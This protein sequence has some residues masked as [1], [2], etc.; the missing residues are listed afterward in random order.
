[1]ALTVSA[2]IAS[3]GA[4]YMQGSQGMNNLKAKLYRGA[5]FDSLF[6]SFTQEDTIVRNVKVS[7]GE[8]LQPFQKAHTPKGGVT[9]LPQ[10]INL[11]KL[12]ADDEIYPD[13]IEGTYVTF[14]AGDGVKREDW[15]IIRYWVEEVMIKQ[16]V[17]DIDTHAFTAVYAAPTAGT[18]AAAS[19]SIDGFR[20]IIQNL[21]ADVSSGINVIATGALSTT[22]TTF[23][24]QVE[25]FVAGMSPDYI[26]SQKE[27]II[28][29]SPANDIKFR[30]GMRTLYNGNYEQTKDL[31]ALIDY[32][33]VK[34]RG[35]QAMSGSS[36]IFATHK[37]NL[38]LPLRRNS[39]E[40]H[41]WAD[42]RLVKA[43]HDHWRGYGVVDPRL[44]YTNDLE[45]T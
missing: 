20:K 2:L 41:V 8:V 1:M 43:Q 13:E 23:V 21:V 12:K 9:L 16:L 14:L 35:F 19:T 39:Q 22:A 3:Y 4:Y 15:P 37:A 28:A 38:L 30:K 31:T 11:Y 29:V 24:G 25:A 32:P 5:E 45:N 7:S 10:P 18:A 44:F 26:K 17:E 36:K 42:G 33:N 40:V 27:I 34:V 6:T